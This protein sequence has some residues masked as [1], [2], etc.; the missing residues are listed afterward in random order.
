MMD[1]T[2]TIFIVASLGGLMFFF[3]SR[4]DA[5]IKENGRRIDQAM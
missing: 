1:W 3:M 4:L 2:Q 5:D